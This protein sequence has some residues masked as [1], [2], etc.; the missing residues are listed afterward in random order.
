MFITS[1][2][3]RQEVRPTSC[4][5]QQ[6]DGFQVARAKVTI[7]SRGQSV[8]YQTCFDIL[9]IHRDKPDPKDSVNIAL[10]P[11]KIPSYRQVGSSGTPP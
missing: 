3:S 1:F 10:D 4:R 9:L 7:Q 2:L 5:D 8:K 6:Q 11:Q